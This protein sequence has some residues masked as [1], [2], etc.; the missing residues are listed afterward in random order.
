MTKDGVTSKIPSRT[1]EEIENPVLTTLLIIALGLSVVVVSA[2]IIYYCVTDIWGIV[3][4]M[5]QQ[6][7]KRH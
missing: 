5:M 4:S 3:E 6:H 2:S 1:R 7:R